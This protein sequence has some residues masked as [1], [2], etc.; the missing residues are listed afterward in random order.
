[1]MKTTQPGPCFDCVMNVSHTWGQF[2]AGPKYFSEFWMCGWLAVPPHPGTLLCPPVQKGAKESYSL[3]IEF[4]S[5][6]LIVFAAL[7]EPMGA[8]L[9]P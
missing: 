4:V 9:H 3:G 7:W 8:K 2:T 6:N 5:L 1:M